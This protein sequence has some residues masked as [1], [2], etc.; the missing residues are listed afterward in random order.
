MTTL[1]EAIGDGDA[2]GEGDGS[3]AEAGELDAIDVLE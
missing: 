2:D 3:A 1:R